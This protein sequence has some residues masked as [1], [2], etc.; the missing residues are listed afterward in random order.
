MFSTNNEKPAASES[1]IADDSPRYYDLHVCYEDGERDAAALGI[2]AVE[3]PLHG[4]EVLAENERELGGA[5]RAKPLV[6]VASGNSEVLRAAA[7]MKQVRMLRSERFEADVG[8]LRIAA[9]R[10]KAFE[11]ALALLIESHGW[12]RAALL[13][14]MRSF[15]RLCIKYKAPYVITS[16]A[17]DA[18]GLRRPREMIALGEALGLSH[19]QAKW[20]ITEAPRAVLGSIR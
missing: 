3:F 4:T 1:A 15:L 6:L 9:E 16:G 12:R 20:A 5:S 2:E 14:R 8:L 17:R 10:S 19:A 11:V 13:S 7:K 18:Y